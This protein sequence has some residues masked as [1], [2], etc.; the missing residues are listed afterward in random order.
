MYE[1]PRRQPAQ[2]S[3]GARLKGFAGNSPQR[4]A[5][6]PQQSSKNA[7]PLRIDMNWIA[8]LSQV[9]MMS[10]W[11]LRQKTWGHHTIWDESTPQ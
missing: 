9:G 8:R 5:K 7:S 4:W 6:R 3:H 1:M 10:S 2:R 11:H